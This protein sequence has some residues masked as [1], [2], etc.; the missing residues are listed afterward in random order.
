MKTARIAMLGA[1]ALG[2]CGCAEIW[3]FQ[4]FGDAPDASTEDE[5]ASGDDGFDATIEA[6]SPPSANSGEA[7]DTGGPSDAGNEG[8]AGCAEG[9]TLCG[10]A[11]IPTS[12]DPNHCGGCTACFPNMNCVASTCVCAANTHQCPGVMGCSSN[13]SPNSCGPTSCTT[14]PLLPG[15]TNACTDSGCGLCFGTNTLCNRDTVDAACVDTHSDPMNCGGCGRG[16]PDLSDA[17]GNVPTCISSECV[18]TCNAGLTPCPDAGPTACVNLSS[19]PQNCGLCGRR[20]V[21]DGGDAGTCM[22]NVCH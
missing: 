18:V 14:C 12:N 21:H 2:L 16:C 3:G 9:T 7:G 5:T 17:G 8:E 11:C 4:D 10:G 20:C 6:G 13:L 19:D 1:L 15:G 22:A